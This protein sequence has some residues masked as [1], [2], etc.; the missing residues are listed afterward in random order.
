MPGIVPQAAHEVAVTRRWLSMHVVCGLLSLICLVVI[1]VIDMFE[2][3][4]VMC[5]T[6]V[7]TSLLPEVRW[8]RLALRAARGPARPPHRPSSLV[9][10]DGSPAASA[11]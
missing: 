10:L 6:R 9:Y 11:S 7:L 4:R 5:G 3:T 8:G 2:V 1:S